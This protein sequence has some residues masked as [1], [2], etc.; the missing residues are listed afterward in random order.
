MNDDRPSLGKRLSPLLAG[1]FFRPLSRPTATIY[2]D[3]AD[4]LELASDEGGQLTHADAIALVRDVLAAHPDVKL[5]EEEG[6]QF[7]D[8]RQRAGQ[9]FNRLLEAGWLEERPAT[10]DERWVV[11]SP[12][13]PPLLV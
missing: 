4:R 6:G 9:I 3:C 8:L 12:R 7:A 2:V 11:L 13:L 1:G 5:D 10:L